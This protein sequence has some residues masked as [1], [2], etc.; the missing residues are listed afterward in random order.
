MMSYM[1]LQCPLG[2]AVKYYSQ[3]ADYI[4]ILV[5]N[6]QPVDM[7][8]NFFVN[9]LLLQVWCTSNHMGH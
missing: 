4:I 7:L 2:Q 8:I 5:T 1:M 6:H 9:A 3:K